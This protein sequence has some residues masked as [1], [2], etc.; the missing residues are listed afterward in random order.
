[1][2]ILRLSGQQGLDCTIASYTELLLK[3]VFE[4]QMEAMRRGGEASEDTPPL[5]TPKMQED[6]RGER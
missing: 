2:D 1:M 3:H 4:F 6:A 5:E